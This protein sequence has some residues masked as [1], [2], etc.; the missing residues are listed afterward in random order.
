MVYC[1]EESCPREELHAAHPEDFTRP[2][3]PSPVRPWVP[4]PTC[5]GE[6]CSACG[7]FGTV[8]REV[9]LAAVGDRQPTRV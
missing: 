7:D 3:P 2:E 8:R 4:C 9:A 5:A 6:G 1:R